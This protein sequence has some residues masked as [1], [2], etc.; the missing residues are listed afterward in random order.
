MF[1]E[2]NYAYTKLN[3]T[4]VLKLNPEDFMV[5]EQLSFKP[6]GSG[7][8]AFLWIEKK[9]LNTQHVI[10]LLS[11]F[12]GLAAKHIGYAGLKDKQSISR[13]WFSINLEGLMEPD[14]QEF[15]H[16]SVTIKQVTYH[17]KKLKIGSLTANQF[18]ILLRDIM[19][20]NKDKIEHRL[21]IIS[22]QGVPNYYGPQR[23][24][25]N[26]QNIS[27]AQD[28]FEGKI[29]IHQWSQKSIILSAAR[30]KLFNQLLSQ[31][32]EKYG[33]NQLIS[34][35]VMMLDGTQSIFAVPE[36]SD[37]EIISRFHEADIHPT[38]ALWGQGKLK[39][40]LDLL[41]LENNSKEL[42]SKWCIGLENKGLK[43]Q[44]RAIR[45]IPKKM[46]STWIEGKY[47]QLEFSLPK[48]CYATSVLRELVCVD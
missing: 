31:R 19:P 45:V 27:K 35:E 48:G 8:H 47:L 23:F 13:Q 14:W 15:S 32:L 9:S 28:W 29:K 43:Q 10:Q 1:R 41:I 3:I 40:C 33:W 2:E 38:L 21:S 16:P 6:D 26:N 22:Q 36:H 11:E 5:T 34:G 39:S 17:N 20:Q 7:K 12:T 24:G 46:K 44:R 42:F 25:I 37:A 18:I 4:A 30:S